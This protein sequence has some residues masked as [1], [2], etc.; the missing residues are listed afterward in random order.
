MFSCGDKGKGEE[1]PNTTHNRKLPGKHE[2]TQPPLSSK[3][4]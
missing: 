4:R 1:G 3:H 2:N